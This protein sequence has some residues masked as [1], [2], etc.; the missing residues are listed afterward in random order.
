M[1][2]LMVHPHDIYDDNEPWT[3]R[4][5]YLAQ[6]LRKLGHEIKLVYHLYDPKTDREQ[7]VKR[8]EYDFETIP[9]FRGAFEIRRNYS[10]L[11][12]L[13][14]WSD[15]VHFQKCTNYVAIPA[16]A[17]AYYHGRPVHYD[18][19]DWEQAIF[20]QD[21][22]NPIGSWIYFGQ[23]EKYLVRLVDTISVASNGLQDL[24]GERSFP[25]ER[26]FFVPVGGDLAA[27]SPEVDGSEIREKHKL[28]GKVVLYQGQISGANYV[29]LY[30]QAV[31]LV[32]EKRSDVS[33]LVVGGGD[34][35]DDA[36]KLAGEL[37]VDGR[38]I[39]TDLVPHAMVPKYIAAADVAV[40][41]FAD[42]K[43]ARCKSPLKVVEYMAAGKAIV[44]SRM[45]EVPRMIG[46]AG[47]LVDPES[48][49]EMAGAIEQLLDDGTLRSKLG[50]EARLRAEG[51]YN[52]SNSAKTLVEAYSQALRYHYG[53]SS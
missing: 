20:D 45:G 48:P 36:R 19:D 50:R 8:Q 38:V 24:C 26:S 37:G 31:K 13:A 12:P 33:F 7:A 53:I 29:H 43:Q 4:I 41:S 40:A 27:F 44:A 23:M 42:N 5:T 51:I 35:L 2:I 52:W 34:K 46:E 3:V 10:I 17:A 15:I 9:L 21:N 6:E 49:E 1:R 39:F 32:L 25:E 30:L 14:H 28:D 47:L 22:H 18:W 11:S 16:I